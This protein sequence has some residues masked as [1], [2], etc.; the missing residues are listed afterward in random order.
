[1]P[2]DDGINLTDAEAVALAFRIV[3]DW[4]R[5]DERPQWEDLPMLGEHAFERLLEQFLTV[6]E[7]LERHV[8]EVDK[9]EAIDS[10]ALLERARG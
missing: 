4:C 7:T 8:S 6:A 3:V 1:M 2:S 5:H 10:S 9:F